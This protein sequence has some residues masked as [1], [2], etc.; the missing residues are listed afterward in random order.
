MVFCSHKPFGYACSKPAGHIGGCAPTVK[1]ATLDTGKVATCSYCGEPL[2]A[3]E[4]DYCSA[5]C[6]CYADR[7][8]QE[9]R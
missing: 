1:L 8:N 7:D 2:P 9:G 3:N 4:T 5:L 6:A